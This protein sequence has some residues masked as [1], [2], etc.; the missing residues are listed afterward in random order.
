MIHPTY[1]LLL[2]ALFLLA[3]QKIIYDI[4]S[5]KENKFIGVIMC[6]LFLIY[7]V[8]DKIFDPFNH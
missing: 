2:I 3:L 5:E 7:E 1:N 8:K 6:F 4:Y